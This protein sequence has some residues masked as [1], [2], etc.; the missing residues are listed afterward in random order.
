MKK[1]QQ[2]FYAAR[3]YKNGGIKWISG[4]YDAKS[5]T[6][7]RAVEQQIRQWLIKEKEFEGEFVITAF[8]AV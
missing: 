6:S 2:Y 7:G 1:I 4:V 8:N 5:D 3:G